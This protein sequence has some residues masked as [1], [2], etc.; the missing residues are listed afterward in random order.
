MKLKRDERE[1]CKRAQKDRLEKK[2]ARKD[3]CIA[4]ENNESEMNAA[5][6]HTQTS[7]TETII[8]GKKSPRKTSTQ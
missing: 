8:C 5:K 6:D 1:I 4:E 7:A 3:N 2:N